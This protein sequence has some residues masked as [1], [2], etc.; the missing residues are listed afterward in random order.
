MLDRLWI[1]KY[2]IFVLNTL[3]ETKISDF[4]PVS[5]TT[6]ILVTFKVGIHQHLQPDEIIYWN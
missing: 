2:R 1:E 3:S 4:F 6:S 5:K